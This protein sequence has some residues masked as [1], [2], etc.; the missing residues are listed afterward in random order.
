M[1]RL[2]LFAVDPQTPRTGSNGRSVMTR[3]PDQSRRADIDGIRALAILA[4]L[5]Y[6]AMPAAAPA[7][8][9]GVDMFIVVSGFVITR[10]LLREYAR[11]GDVSIRDFY[12]RRARRLL[13]ALMV[14]LALVT[15]AAHFLLLPVYMK[16]FARNMFHALSFTVNIFNAQNAGYFGRAAV[17]DPFL[18]LWSLALEEQFYLVAPFF[19]L[20]VLRRFPGQLIRILVA[21]TVLSWSLHFVDRVPERWLFYLPPGRLWEFGVGGL[22]ACASQRVAIRRPAA[23]W[24]SIAGVVAVVFCVT[25]SPS[26]WQ[27]AEATMVVLGTAAMIGVGQEGVRTWVG[28]GLSWRP[29]QHLG[30]MSYSLYLWHWPLLYFVAHTLP[31]KPPPVAIASVV[32]AA[33]ILAAMSYRFIEQPFLTGQVSVR[34]SLLIAAVLVLVIGGYAGLAL[35][36]RGLPHRML[37]AVRAY[38]DAIDDFRWCSKAPDGAPLGYK[39]CRFGAPAGRLD[40][41][42]LGNS[43]AQMYV[44]AFE[45]ILAET[46]RSG[47]APFIPLCK[48]F[49]GLNISQPCLTSMDRLIDEMADLPGIDRIVIAFDWDEGPADRVWR[50]RDG[51]QDLANGQ[52]VAKGLDATIDRLR[53]K[54]KTVFLIGP[55]AIPNG[56]T[57]INM[58]KRM[59]LGLSTQD[60][61]LGEDRDAFDARWRMLIDRYADDPRLRA[62]I[63]PD[64]WQCGDRCWYVRDG[65]MLFADFSH[66]TTSAAAE[67]APM[68]RDA[69]RLTPAHPEEP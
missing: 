42:L 34:W 25:G 47:F 30:R 16:I 35:A 32:A 66:L 38:S 27:V 37:P 43:H 1:A 64:R 52:A 3:S 23:Q 17:D 20:G 58:A 36:T 44:P 29:L 41:I 51:R 26:Q 50:G 45:Q 65:R 19:L 9:Y 13:P 2:G 24:L 39:G 5:L 59:R 53:A 11:S 21:V 6:H 55:I 7:G 56:D 15:I 14:M 61:A 67:L 62:F 57:A 22:L 48:P 8:F 31:E 49:Y 12:R 54:G 60:V 28:A 4:V 68:M 40:T 33:A 63:R 18:H 10:V 46:G 69:L